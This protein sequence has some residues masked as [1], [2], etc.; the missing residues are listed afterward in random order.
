MAAASG[1]LPAFVITSASGVS[2]HL[3][4]GMPMT[5]TSSTS[6]WPAT[7]ASTSV[8][9]TLKP[10]EMIMSFLRSTSVMYPWLSSLPRSPERI[11]LR[12]RASRQTSAAVS[13]GRRW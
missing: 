10:P 13:S 2:P 12:P 7:M 1:A 5:L 9:K 8:G 6:G 11:Q 4:C 3:S